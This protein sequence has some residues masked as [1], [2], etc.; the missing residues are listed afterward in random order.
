[1]ST[2]R[3]NLGDAF[4]ALGVAILGTPL[5]L[6]AHQSW[7]G[8][9]FAQTLSRRLPGY[10]PP[11]PSFLE[12]WLVVPLPLAIALTIFG[13]AFVLFSI[14]RYFGVRQEEEPDAPVDRP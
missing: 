2:Q 8:G 13:V 10:R 5:A 9:G 1:M 11:G 14:L 12:E 6:L 7:L 3:L 4:P